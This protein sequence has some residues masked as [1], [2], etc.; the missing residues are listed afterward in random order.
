MCDDS[1]ANYKL[2][3]DLYYYSPLRSGWPAMP[4]LGYGI[5]RINSVVVLSNAN[6]KLLKQ[7]FHWKAEGSSS[8]AVRAKLAAKRLK[9][10]NQQMSIIF[11]NP[12]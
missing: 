12:F 5:V 3:D 9:T 10:S 6:S 4:P 2:I 11:R 1:V 7:A 8:E